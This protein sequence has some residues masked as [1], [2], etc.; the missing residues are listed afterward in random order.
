MNQPTTQW[1]PPFTDARNIIVGNARVIWAKA[2]GFLPEGWATPGGGRTTNEAEA[3]R[4][5][6]EMH[7]LMG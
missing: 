7:Q 5:A 3:R 2:N 1:A 6:F 4:V